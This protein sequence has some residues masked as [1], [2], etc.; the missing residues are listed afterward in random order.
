MG[1]ARGAWLSRDDPRAF[2]AS[3]KLEVVHA[4]IDDGFRRCIP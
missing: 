2:G 1:F 4:V 3:V